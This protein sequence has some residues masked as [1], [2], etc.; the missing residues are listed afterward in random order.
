MRHNI[1]V[2][3]IEDLSKIVDLPHL[4][5][6]KLMQGVDFGAT[7][8]VHELMF[9]RTYVNRTLSRLDYNLYASLPQVS[10]LKVS[11]LAARTSLQVRYQTERKKSHFNLSDFDCDSHESSIF[12]HFS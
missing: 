1:C 4:M 8:C 2:F 9:N 11:L 6:N 12:F 3:G 7:V 10:M 5:V